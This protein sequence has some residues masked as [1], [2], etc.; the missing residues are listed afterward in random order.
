MVKKHK[1][2]AS[3]TGLSLGEDVNNMPSTE[4]SALVRMIRHTRQASY[5]G[6]GFPRRHT[7]QASFSG[8]SLGWKAHKTCVVNCT[9]LSLG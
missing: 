3:C 8:L 9:G 1:R 4:A 6:V 2:Q 7:K 5:T